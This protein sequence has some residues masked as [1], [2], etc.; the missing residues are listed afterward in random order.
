VSRTGERIRGLAAMAGL[1]VLVVV[2]PLALAL[3]VGWPL[4][5][6]VPSLEEIGALDGVS[7]T[8][9]VKA[10]AVLAWL[11]WAQV[12]L[13]VAVEAAALVRRRVARRVSVVGGLQA[14]VGRLVAT[15]ALVAATWTPPVRPAPVPVSYI[16]A[17]AS[18]PA[19]PA[20]A[21]EGQVL[22]GPPQ[23]E[24]LAVPDAGPAPNATGAATSTH[25]V[26]RNE[27]WWSIAE[28]HLG[29]GL[30]WRELQSANVGRTMPDGS[31][32][33]PGTELIRPGWE[34]LV[35][36]DEAAVTASTGTVTM[37]EVEVRR[38]DNLWSMT[39]RQLTE[40]NGHTPT[41]AE[42]VGPWR[43]VIE[44]NRDRLRD[45]A[46]PSL[47]YPGQVMRMPGPAAPPV[48]GNGAPPAPTEPAV[49]SAPATVPSPEQAAP[50]TTTAPPTTEAPR[51]TAPPGTRANSGPRAEA[52]GASVDA[53]VRAQR[54]R[55]PLGALGTA[56][57]LLAV[58]IA[59]ALARRRWQRRQELPRR[60]L[61][62]DP[63]VELDDLRSELV[64]EADVEDVTR[65]RR[66]IEHLGASLA[67]AG[68]QSR[69][70][71]VQVTSK[72]VEVLL[73][74]PAPGVQ[75][76]WRAEAS[77]AAWT[78]KGDPGEGEGFDPAPGLVSLGRPDEATELY[79]DLEAEGV[80]ALVGDDDAV[81][82]LARS[83]ALELSSSPLASGASVLLV[84]DVLDGVAES[85]RLRRAASWTELAGE[86]EGWI[87]EA[88]SVMEAK[89]WTSAFE[90]RV[91]TGD[92]DDLA[93]VVVVGVEPG[94]AGSRLCEAIL[95]GPAPAAAVLL[96]A[97][98][99]GATRIQVGDGSLRI[100]SL[101][102][103]CEAQAVEA[104][105]ARQ[106][107]EL[108]QD[109]GRVPAQLS[110]LPEPVPPE[111]PVVAGE[112]YQDPPYEVL[113]RVL[114]DIRVEGSHRPLKPK[115]TAVLAYIALNAPAA[116]EKIEDAIWVA[117][118][119]SRRKRLANTVSETRTALGHSHLPPASDGR[120]RVGPGVMTDIE[121]FERR[122]SY[123]TGQDEEDAL[124]TIRGALEL[125][126]GPVFT[127]RH[128][129]RGAYV[130]VD[131]E[132]WI[133]TWEL[134]V[135]EA[136]EDL[137]E[138]YLEAGDGKAAVWAARR[139]LKAANNHARLTTILCD[140]YQQKGE[141]SAA[142]KVMAS[143]EAGLVE[144]GLV[145]TEVS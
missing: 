145:D 79:L 23:N 32:V 73:T 16:A 26:Q 5:R 113:V 56:G 124:A 57:T 17:V 63:P 138:R 76:P 134:R 86:L 112:E 90:G 123:A 7:D 94:E 6:S 103:E 120:Y 41:D 87:E 78:I 88:S 93:P 24:V 118:T 75:P 40:V 140:L 119:A 92:G 142:K 22:L 60:G 70:R 44:A 62:P 68:T 71:L 111:I 38:G 14:G 64:L 81:A 12:T 95:S 19:P 135:T 128:A 108:L 129:E 47:I 114:G 106:V 77:G 49:P 36:G 100:P 80:V 115:Q 2:P 83:W 65:L 66:A 121:L 67:A 107:E 131:V 10:L 35:P 72:T 144:L 34:L 143:Y 45:P 84:G 39:E 74:S 43:E 96:G 104:E 101:G 33:A 127:Y 1:V 105:T 28:E 132:N 58:G 99:N 126:E 25:L 53:P 42:V 3:L 98:V 141:T 11:V 54:Q 85:D 61:P 9:V 116:S 110:F 55:A 82:D 91:A 59:G 8:V 46:N 15:A 125:V 137:A 89:G 50:S 52:G 136:A 29:D 18:E 31:V 139:G 117:P 20:T 122:L 109:A 130:W 102:L 51:T 133:S 4:P 13:A 27:S 30:R 48:N 69:P 97:E 37:T 21:P